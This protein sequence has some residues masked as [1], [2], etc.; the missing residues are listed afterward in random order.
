MPRRP[1]SFSFTE[2]GVA[3]ARA[4]NQQRLAEQGGKYVS[5]EYAMDIQIYDTD[6]MNALEH[7][8][9]NAMKA[10][11]RDWETKR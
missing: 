6:V 7:L 11:D 8:R 5:R 9:K 10:R 4:R 1:L 2:R 3:Y